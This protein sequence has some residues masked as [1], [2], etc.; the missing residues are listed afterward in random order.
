MTGD[1]RQVPLSA[2][3]LSVQ[4]TAELAHNLTIPC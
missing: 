3:T 4:L 1:L 2:L